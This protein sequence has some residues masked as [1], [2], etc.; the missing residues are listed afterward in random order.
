MRTTRAAAARAAVAGQLD[1]KDSTSERVTTIA[2]PS[3]GREPLRSITPNSIDG[4]D[5]EKPTDDETMPTKKAKAKGKK[6]AARTKKGCQKAKT[7]MAGGAPTIDE[8]GSGPVPAD[9]EKDI[10]DNRADVAP[11]G[12]CV[13]GVEPRNGTCYR[14]YRDICL[15]PAIRPAH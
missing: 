1:N 7:N 9:S 6:K 13:A 3:Y 4:G 14:Q 8:Y 5:I 10:G 15:I 2:L 11:Q 12:E